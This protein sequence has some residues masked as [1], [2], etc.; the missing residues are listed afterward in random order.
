MSFKVSRNGRTVASLR[1]TNTPLY[2]EGGGPPTPIRFRNATI[3]KN[4]TFTSTGRY[5]IKSGPLKG[6]IGT[7]L[8][9]TGV[10]LGGSRE[11][12]TLTTTYLKEPK[13]SGSSSYTT[14]A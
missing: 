4:G 7:K 3:S 1:I 5:V 2:C 9:I 13:C 10:F 14:M 12:G 11:R 6:Q 8:T